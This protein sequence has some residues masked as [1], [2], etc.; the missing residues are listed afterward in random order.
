MEIT[1][2]IL[3]M[4]KGGAVMWP[5]YALLVITM[6]LSIER[7]IT[8]FLIWE[9]HSRMHMREI[10]PVLSILDLIAMIAPVIGFLGTVTGM[11]N[12]FRS[13]AEASSVQLQIIASGLYEALYTTAFGLIISII[14]T[15]SSFI[16]ETASTMLC[17][18]EE[19]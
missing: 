3:I 7:G 17:E 15:I 4:K 13:V 19:T 14:A 18:T 2:L 1:N 5:L 11:I 12:A 9:N 16:L 8:L 6:V 10:E